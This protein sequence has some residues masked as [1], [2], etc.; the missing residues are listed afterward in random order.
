MAPP[1]TALMTAED[2]FDRRDEGYRCELS[3]ESSSG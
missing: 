3:R 2:L 1:G